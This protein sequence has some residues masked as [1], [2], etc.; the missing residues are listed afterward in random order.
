[1]TDCFVLFFWGGSKTAGVSVLISPP[2]GLSLAVP[3]PVII[4]MS[5][6]II[7]TGVHVRGHVAVTRAVPVPRT[8]TP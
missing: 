3:G 5:A 2:R 1:M 8:A 6:S 7:E 4:M